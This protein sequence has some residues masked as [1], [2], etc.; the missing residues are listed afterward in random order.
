MSVRVIASRVGRSKSAVQS[1]MHG[2]RNG[3]HMK[4]C[5]PK[6]TVTKTQHR[7]I[8]RAASTGL[9]IAREVHSIYRCNVSVRRVQQMMQKAPHLKYRKM[10]TGPYLTKLHQEKRVDWEKNYVH[11][12]RRWRRVVFSDEKKFNLDGPDGFA[13]YWHDLRKEE[14]YFS[15]R[16]QRGSGVTIWAAISYYGLSSIAVIDGTMDSDKYIKVLDK[17]LLPFAAEDC[18]ID[19][20]YQQDNAPCHTSKATK[21][22]LSDSSVDLLPLSAKSP[23]LNIIENLRGVLV[24]DVYKNSQQYENKKE[25]KNAIIACWNK[26]EDST[27]QNMYDSMHKR[28]IQVIERDGR[29]TKY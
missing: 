28:C 14:K 13:Y 20:I 15:K 24:R 3:K 25:L 17:C 7:A 22:Y 12:C 1:L 26:I 5:G 16:Q 23:D 8:V 11:W 4:R 21:E 10:Q 2:L 27:I 29:K 6:S 18:P 19:W 9:H